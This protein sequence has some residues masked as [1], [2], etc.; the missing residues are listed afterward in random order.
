MLK[1]GDRL[2]IK[3]GTAHLLS[4]GGAE[5]CEFLLIQGVGKYDWIKAE[6]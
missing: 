3:P 5:D 1:V 2:Q 6:G 4:N